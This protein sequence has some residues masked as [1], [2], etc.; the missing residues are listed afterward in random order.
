E[1]D[2]NPFDVDD[3]SDDEGA[4]ENS[5][6]V[7][8]IP[9]P[10]KA[11]TE[12]TTL[13]ICMNEIGSGTKNQI[14]AAFMSFDLHKPD[15]SIYEVL[16]TI[17]KQAPA[18][19]TLL[20]AKLGY[21]LSKTAPVLDIVSEDNFTIVLQLL[22]QNIK[23]FGFICYGSQ[24]DLPTPAASAQSLRTATKVLSRPSSEVLTDSEQQLRDLCC[25]T[26]SVDEEHKKGCYRE[27]DLHLLLT[28]QHFRQWVVILD[29][30]RDK[31]CTPTMPP[32][33]ASFNMKNAKRISA[34]LQPALST[35]CG[36]LKTPTP[37]PS[38]VPPAAPV[39]SIQTASCT[40]ITLSDKAV[41]VFKN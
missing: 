35:P 16:G 34:S 19:W 22:H 28:A 39:L 5:D 23:T 25:G 11:K 8:Q 40:F 27:G 36:P 4:D 33:A 10:K 14:G 6:P 15:I 2:D 26:C 3:S 32:N 24:N 21:K 18:K 31:A 38:R 17:N 29:H 12:Q 9:V 30:G 37:A 20:T 7:L 41:P 1:M 13:L